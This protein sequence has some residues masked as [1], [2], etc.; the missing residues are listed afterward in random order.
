MYSFRMLCAIAD[1]GLIAAPHLLHVL[2]EVCGW[3]Q[4]AWWRDVNPEPVASA[5]VVVSMHVFFI[6]VHGNQDAQHSY[7][8]Y[9]LLWSVTVAVM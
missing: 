5:A 7:K 6:A 2:R 3:R 9:E 4:R 8:P 1:A